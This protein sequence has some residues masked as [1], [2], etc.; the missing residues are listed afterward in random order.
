MDTPNVTSNVSNESLGFGSAA[1]EGERIDGL[2]EIT[3]QMVWAIKQ[4]RVATWH[5]ECDVETNPRP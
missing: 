1:T 2:R 5:N 3:A 4:Y